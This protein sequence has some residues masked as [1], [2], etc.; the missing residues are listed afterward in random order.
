VDG[1][2]LMMA[3]R[4]RAM[5]KDV[6]TECVSQEA[7]NAQELFTHQMLSCPRPQALAP[8]SAAKT[9]D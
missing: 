6:A 8:E 7:L 2:V 5:Q 1:F 4:K 9:L 3:R